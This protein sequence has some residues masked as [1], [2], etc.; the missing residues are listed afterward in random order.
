[1]GA[2][3]D[4]ITGSKENQKLKNKTGILTKTWKWICKWRHNWFYYSVTGETTEYLLKKACY[5]FTSD[6][7]L[8][9]AL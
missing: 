2:W 4:I 7:K 9:K 3:A 5:M 6:L 1:M 8:T